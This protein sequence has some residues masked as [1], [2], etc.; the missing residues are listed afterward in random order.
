MKNKVNKKLSKFKNEVDNYN[1]TGL[2]NSV[3]INKLELISA[4]NSNNK[5][6]FVNML[7]KRKVYILMFYLLLS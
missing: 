2:N 5:Q 6:T 1:N 4:Y 7:D 3:F